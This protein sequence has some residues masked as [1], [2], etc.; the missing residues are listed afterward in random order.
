MDEAFDAQLCRDYPNLYQ[1]R[2]GS[3]TETLMCWGFDT[4]PG[5]NSLIKDLSAKLEQEILSLPEEQRKHFYAQQVKSKFAVLRFYMSCETDKMSQLIMDAEALSAI[6][7][8]LCGQ[9]GKSKDIVGWY[10][11]LCNTCYKSHMVYHAS[12]RLELLVRHGI[13][14]SKEEW[15]ECRKESKQ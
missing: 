2:N 12:S 11:T 6:T 10:M 9:P 13:E 7:C 1:M 4:Q 5:W 3:I 8:E 14:V 15:D